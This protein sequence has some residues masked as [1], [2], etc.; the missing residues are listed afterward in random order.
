MSGSR[1]SGTVHP[2]AG[3]GA[4]LGFSD[5]ANLVD[6]IAQGRQDGR[7]PGELLL[8]KEYEAK[9]MA[10][11]VQMMAAIDGVQKLFSSQSDFVAALRGVGFGAVN[12]VPQIR[13]LIAQ[14]AVQWGS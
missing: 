6:A 11:N 3:Q 7:D 5:V 4:N 13:R 10:S 1:W 12:A 8:L 2:L 14:N 9:A